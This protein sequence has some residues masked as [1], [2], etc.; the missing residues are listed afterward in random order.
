[1]I[2]FTKYTVV[3]ENMHWSLCII[4]FVTLL[5]IVR[6]YKL[7]SSRVDELVPDEMLR[8]LLFVDEMPRYTRKIHYF[9]LS[10]GSRKL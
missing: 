1:M 9:G 2:F 7:R 3:Y 4:H 10:K 6:D 8:L 5:F